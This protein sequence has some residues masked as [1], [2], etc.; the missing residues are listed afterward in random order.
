MSSSLL[1]I[2]NISFSYPD[3]KPVFE[4]IDLDI[5]EGTL[6]IIS[7]ESGTGKS[8]FL[9]LFNRFH[10]LTNGKILFHE[11]ELREY[12]ISEIRRSI[13]YLPQL[14][15]MIEGCVEDN[16][17]FPFTF[18]AQKDKK[19]SPVKAREWLDYFQLGV[20]L[21]H[22]AS[23]LSVGQRQRIALIR[24]L[25]LEPEVLLLDEPCSALD[26]RNRRLIE[27]KIESLVI[28]GGVTVIMATHGE[29]NF[30]ESAC[31]FFQLEDGQ[32]KAMQ[33][34]SGQGA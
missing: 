16:L 6:S 7:G 13:L 5:K 33:S 31:A 34:H 12:Q 25:L 10:D 14:P 4:R 28:S 1:K 30:S 19:Y 29:V 26:S 2:Q 3:G 15:H 8:T 17:S 11:R 21:S 22:E 32:L 9:K 18:Q 27:E 24:A 23:K 20:S